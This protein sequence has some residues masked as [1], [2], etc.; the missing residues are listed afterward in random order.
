MS[1]KVL[2]YQ[3]Q[4][5]LDA[6]LELKAPIATPS[7]TGYCYV[8][9]YG[10]FLEVRD[11]I[12]GTATLGV[13]SYAGLHSDR[14]SLGDA[15]LK[16]QGGRKLIL[17]AAY[18]FTNCGISL[19][20]DSNTITL[21]GNLTSNNNLT[22]NGT[23]TTN[24][25]AY[26]N[27]YTEFASTVQ[28]NREIRSVASQINSTEPNFRLVHTNSGTILRQDDSFFYFLVTNY[29]SQWSNFNALRPFTITNNTGDVAMGSNV[30][31]GQ[32]SSSALPARFAVAS[33]NSGTSNVVAWNS[34]WSI[35]GGDGTASS[36]SLGIGNDG[37]NSWMVS[38]AP[39]VAWKNLNARAASHNWYDSGD[40]SPF[41]S[42]SA[43][44]VVL[45]TGLNMGSYNITSGADIQARN[46]TATGHLHS[47]SLFVHSSISAQTLQLFT[48]GVDINGNI[49]GTSLALTG[50]VTS[51][52]VN[53][54][55]ITSSGAVTSQSLSVGAGS[56]GIS[57]SGNMTGASLTVSGNVNSNV[58]NAVTVNAQY[59]NVS[60]LC[61]DGNLN[62]SGSLGVTDNISGLSLNAGDSVLGNVNASLLSVSGNVSA[63]SL[64]AGDSVLGNVTAYLL[65]VG[66]VSA[67]SLYVS[68]E[69]LGP[70]ISIGPMGTLMLS[71]DA[72]VSTITTN[73]VYGINSLG[74]ISAASLI[75]GDSAFGN[76][77]VLALQSYGNVSALSLTTSVLYANTST[78]GLFDK[79]NNVSSALQ[80]VN[81]ALN[82]TGTVS[83]PE[84]A[85]TVND[86]LGLLRSY[87]LMAAPLP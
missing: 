26:L 60:C 69:I 58:V 14:A 87:G 21:A 55:S 10:S 66:N 40:V 45:N 74:N 15:V 72:T 75:A 30:K 24:N 44:G 49:T 70:N 50:G 13:A 81:I 18:N 37:S 12:Y 54:G 1:A 17:Q 52:S 41:L 19:N 43:A 65:S 25:H 51:A 29:G 59:M 47:A 33:G 86:I 78:L 39:G 82:N 20:G 83:L 56:S 2:S 53:S 22:V 3:N 63:L 76:V 85:Q 11:D 80:Y 36:S 38:L 23:L 28:A 9:G 67:S 8:R 48:A 64:N 31:I 27:S 62:V 73:S 34:G 46:I 79:A 77:S 42:G 71:G 32:A 7:L 16:S 61:W 4:T 35:F 84:C 6:S 5:Q 57:S 68:G